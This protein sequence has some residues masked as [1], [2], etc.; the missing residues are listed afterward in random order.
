MQY[1]LLKH[2]TLEDTFGVPVDNFEIYQSSKPSLFPNDVTIE[3]MKNYYVGQPA[4]NQLDDYELLTVELT[5]P[6]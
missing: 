2:K 5:F 3:F 1:K 4:Y 6:E